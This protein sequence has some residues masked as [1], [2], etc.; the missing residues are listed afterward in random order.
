[1]NYKVANLLR[2]TL[3]LV[4]LC[5]SGLSVLFWKTVNIVF[6]LGIAIIILGMLIGAA[7]YRCPKCG[8][9]LIWRP[10]NLKHCQNC[11]YKLR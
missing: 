10:L 1:M 9:M 7:Y 8:H 2:F 3:I 11:G 6:G 4:G 5:V